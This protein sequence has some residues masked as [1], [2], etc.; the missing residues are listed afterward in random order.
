MGNKFRVHGAGAVRQ[1]FVSGIA[2]LAK[3]T[4]VGGE[5]GVGGSQV[6][7]GASE[8]NVGLGEILNRC[9]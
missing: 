7:V 4:E 3:F 5:L 2:L 6:G 1:F 9:C 8:F